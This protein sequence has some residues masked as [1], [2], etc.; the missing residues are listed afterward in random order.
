MHDKS[1]PVAGRAE[2]GSRET[3]RE[4]AVT[5]LGNI[6]LLCWRHA[7]TLEGAQATRRAFAR[8]RSA[9]GRNER[10]GF[11]TLVEEPAL[12]VVPANARAEIATLLGENNS[13]IGAGAVVFE[14]NGFRATVFRSIITAINLA[15]RPSFPNEVFAD[16]LSG[17]TWLV[18]EM[19]SST[20]VTSAEIIDTING[21]RASS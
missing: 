9:R 19:G 16:T 17:A 5:T 14:G 11:Y 8:L 20:A 21:L 7:T 3:A 4:Y 12:H 6:V 1:Q 18:H 13:V 10:V 15:S 2:L